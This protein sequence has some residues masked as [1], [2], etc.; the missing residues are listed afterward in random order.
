MLYITLY[1]TVQS[2]D[3]GVCELGCSSDA[4]FIWYFPV[5]AHINSMST[6]V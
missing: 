5:Q 3:E 4:E 2:S 1:E 6:R